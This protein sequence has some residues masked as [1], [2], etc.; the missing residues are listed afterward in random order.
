[1]RN[2]ACSRRSDREDSEKRYEQKK[3]EGWG[4]LPG[5][6]ATEKVQISQFRE[7]LCYMKF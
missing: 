7:V 4:S 5:V 3:H 1:M 2:I 6:R